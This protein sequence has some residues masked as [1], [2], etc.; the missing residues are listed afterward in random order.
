MSNAMRVIAQNQSMSG[1]AVEEAVLKARSWS[2][3]K[4]QKQQLRQ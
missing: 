4:K 2:A 3:H 1:Q